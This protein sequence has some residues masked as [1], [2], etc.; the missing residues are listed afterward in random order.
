MAYDDY[1]SFEEPGDELHDD[2][3]PDPDEFDDDTTETVPCPECGADV[4]EDAEQCPA[5]GVYITHEHSALAGRPGW[6][7]VLAV[8]GI[9]AT[10]VVLLAG[11]FG[12]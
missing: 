12:P 9:L 11:F 8:L 4:Y 7:I 1:R 10:V 6:W 5:C 2:E 3:Y